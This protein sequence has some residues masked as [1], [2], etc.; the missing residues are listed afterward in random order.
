MSTSDEA[1]QETSQP[2]KPAGSGGLVQAALDPTAVKRQVQQIQALMD[3]VMKEGEHYDNPN[4]SSSPILK[5]A[6]AEKICFSFRLVAEYDVTVTNISQKREDLPPGHREYVAEC[7][8]KDRNGRLLGSLE[9]SCSTAEPKYRFRKKDKLTDFEPPKEFWGSYEDSMANAD[10]SIL[11]DL[12]MEKGEELPPDASIGVSKDDQ[13]GN[14]HISIEG[15]VEN[16]EIEAQYN[17]CRKMSQ[18]RAYVGTVQQVTAASDIFT[19]DLDDPDLARQVKEEKGAEAQGSKK[20]SK[21][22][23]GERGRGGGS[24]RAQGR[25]PQ[26]GQEKRQS[27]SSGQGGGSSQEN[28]EKYGVR[29][30]PGNAEHVEAAKSSIRSRP[31]NVSFEVAADQIQD[32]YGSAPEPLQE[33]IE[34]MIAEER[35]NDDRLDGEQQEGGFDGGDVQI[36]GEPEDESSAQQEQVVTLPGDTPFREK[37]VDAGITN[38]QQLEE[39]WKEDEL[40]E[41]VDGVGPKRAKKIAEE[42]GF[43]GQSEAEQASQNGETQNGEGSGDNEWD[44]WEDGDPQDKFDDDPP[45]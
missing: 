33:A 44:G 30:S 4:W 8:L 3:E 32:H 1:L 12:L 18:K 15:K 21:R 5:K 25:S 29:L 2:P 37:L 45:F 35:P 19:Q 34:K 31:Q 41:S 16:P 38:T 42:M 24:G 40:A 14:W 27:R 13:T 9:G 11:R 36:S 43:A 17:T 28:V 23:E 6:G 39:A 22:R 20:G 10:F 7:R 26:R